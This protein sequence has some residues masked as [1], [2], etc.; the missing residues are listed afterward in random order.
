[1][2]GL[3]LNCIGKRGPWCF[4][5]RKWSWS[6]SPQYGHDLDKSRKKL[7]LI[8]CHLNIWL[9]WKS[10]HF[11]FLFS[12]QWSMHK[13]S[14]SQRVCHPDFSERPLGVVG[15]CLTLCTMRKGPDSKVHG[16]NMGPI[17]ARQ[18]PGG[19]HVGHMNLAIWGFH[20]LRWCSSNP[21]S[22]KPNTFWIA[23]FCKVMVVPKYSASTHKKNHNK[24]IVTIL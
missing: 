8:P 2:P 19:P 6:N 10:A 18:D 23:Y 24:N 7:T 13:L 12:H 22:T 14:S 4:H 16:A 20:C 3:K 5:S 15:R 21:L 9:K 1:M 17:W 11:V